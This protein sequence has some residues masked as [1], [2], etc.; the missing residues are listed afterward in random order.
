MAYLFVQMIKFRRQAL[1]DYTK[2]ELLCQSACQRK[3]LLASEIVFQNEYCSNVSIF[4][5]V[6]GFTFVLF[7]LF[8]LLHVSLLP[9]LLFFDN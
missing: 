9:H 5:L 2:Y 7:L 4:C 6:L 1:A 3:S 8:I